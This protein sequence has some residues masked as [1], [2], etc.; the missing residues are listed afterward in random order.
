MIEHNDRPGLR[1]TLADLEGRC[2]QLSTPDKSPSF[3]DELRRVCHSLQ[4]A[5]WS[6]EE[7]DG[8][9]RFFRDEPSRIV[10]G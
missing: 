2:R 1:R 6:T 7:S 10:R 8:L 5:S 4:R 9:K 3:A